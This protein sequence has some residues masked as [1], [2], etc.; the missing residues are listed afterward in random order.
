[1][2]ILGQKY[3]FTELELKR[4]EKKFSNIQP[5]IYKDNQPEDVIAQIERVTQLCF[6]AHS[7][8]H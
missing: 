2:L 4:L 5:I 8:K 6:Y 7:P 3:T 1:M